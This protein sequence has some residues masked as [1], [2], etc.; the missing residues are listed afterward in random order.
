MT[1]TNVH[2]LRIATHGDDFTA[3]GTEEALNWLQVEIAERFEVEL[4]GRMGP[5]VND[6]KSIRLLSRVFDRTSEGIVM[7]ADQGH[8]EQTKRGP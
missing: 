3:L 2:E 1:I 4:R 7:E 5:G 6:E 8:A